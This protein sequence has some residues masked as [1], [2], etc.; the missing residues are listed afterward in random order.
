MEKITKAHGSG[1]VRGRWTDIDPTK[2]D[3]PHEVPGLELDAGSFISPYDVPDGVRLGRSDDERYLIELRYLTDQEKIEFTETEIPEIHF[4]LGCL[5]N[6]L[7]SVQVAVPTE[8]PEW[9][10]VESVLSQLK[11][12]E[13]FV[14]HY[15]AISVLRDLWSLLAEQVQELETGQ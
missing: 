9:E 11:S 2:Y 14:N 13:N 1:A 6:R 12:Q 10:A 4:G 15:V 5:S 7:V 3:E 8:F